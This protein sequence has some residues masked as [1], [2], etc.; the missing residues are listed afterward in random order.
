MEPAGLSRA[1]LHRREYNLKENS[2]PLNSRKLKQNQALLLVFVS[3]YCLELG[4]FN[5]L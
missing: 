1:A 2:A 4:L 5:E 3:F